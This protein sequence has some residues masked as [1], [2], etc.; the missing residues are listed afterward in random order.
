MK[1]AM[2]VFLCTVCVV[3]MVVSNNQV[4]SASI[5][6]SSN[7]IFADISPSRIQ[8]SAQN[9][10]DDRQPSENSQISTSLVR[11]E[12]SVRMAR[13]KGLISRQLFGSNRQLSDFNPFDLLGL[14]SSLGAVALIL[15][16]QSTSGS[17]SAAS[18]TVSNGE[19]NFGNI[20]NKS[21]SQNEILQNNLFQAIGG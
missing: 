9:I 10:A 19:V 13:R 6:G 3:L 4:A 2:S 7:S 20:D 12:R 18:D 11:A 1:K 16:I 8:S 17:S 15:Y 5:H 14:F 21:T